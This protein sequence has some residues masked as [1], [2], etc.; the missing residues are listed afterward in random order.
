MRELLLVIGAA[1]VLVGGIWILQGADVLKGSFMTGQSRWLWIGI[2]S[3]LG[4]VVV[5]AGTLRSSRR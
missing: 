2:G 4:G 3:V 5:L 1:L